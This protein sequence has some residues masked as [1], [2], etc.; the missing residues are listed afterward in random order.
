M[1]VDFAGAGLL[2]GLDGEERAARLELLERLEAEGATLDELRGAVDDGLLVFLPAERL[3]GG[4][5]RHRARDVG[6]SIESLA[7]MR[8]AHGLP[9]PDPDAIALTDLDVEAVRTAASFPGGGR[10]RGADAPRDPRARPRHGPGGRDAAMLVSSDVGAL[11]A[12]AL[13][14]H[15]AAAARPTSSCRWASASHAARRSRARA[16]GT[17]ARSTSPAA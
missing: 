15:D 17:G 13:D 7:A 1:G 6:V 14:L 10:Q 8:R 11:L 9:V 16:T 5:P 4:P 12:C 2:D 3:V